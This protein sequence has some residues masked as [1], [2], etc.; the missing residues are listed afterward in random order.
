MAPGL[1]AIPPEISKYGGE[2]LSLQVAAFSQVMWHHE[3]K[4]QNFKDMSIV[5]LYKK[6][7][8]SF[9]GSNH[10]RISLLAIAGRIYS[11]IIVNRLTYQVSENV[12][13]VSM[14]QCVFRRRRAMT[15]MNFAARQL[16]E[17][18]QE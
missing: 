7:G 17:K 11:R 14:C 9:V 13:P 16:E 1:D 15:D 6:K 18:S 5:H 10:I 4:A 2:A 12:P 3:T 8:D